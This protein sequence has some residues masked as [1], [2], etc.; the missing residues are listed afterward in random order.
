MTD[1]LIKTG[2]LDI[3]T[4]RR[5][6]KGRQKED[7]HPPAK[8]RSFRRKQTWGHLDLRLLASRTVREKTAAVLASQFVL[9]CYSE[10]IQRSVR[11]DNTNRS[12]TWRSL[13]DVILRQCY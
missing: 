1:V 3:D 8:E 2:K 6:T 11:E 13:F 4:F 10:V 12:K 7:N 5:N 9:L